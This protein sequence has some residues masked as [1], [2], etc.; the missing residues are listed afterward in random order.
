MRNDADS[1]TTRP[2][3]ATAQG[4][5]ERLARGRIPHRPGSWL[6]V[7]LRPLVWARD[8]LRALYE[9]LVELIWR[10]LIH[11]ET[12][13]NPATQLKAGAL[14]VGFALVAYHFEGPAEFT[15][16]AVIAL[17]ALDFAMA[18]LR[19][20]RPS[21][22]EHYVLERA[23]DTLVW[24]GRAPRHRPVT[25]ELP[26]RRVRCV[27]VDSLSLA[28][29]AFRDAYRHVW[30][31]SLVLDDDRGLPLAESSHPG[32]VL[33]QGHALAAGLGV[34]LEI[35]GATGV[36]ESI[37]A[38]GRIVP[39]VG[40]SPTVHEIDTPD[41]P[42]IVR[43]LGFGE[44]RELVGEVLEDAGLLLFFLIMAGMLPKIGLFV[45]FVTGY[46]PPVLHLDLSPAGLLGFFTPEADDWVGWTELT[47]AI[48]VL[49][50]STWRH[51]RAR[52]LTVGATVTRYAVG[53]REVATLATRRINA[54]FLVHNPAPLVVVAD[55]RGEAAVI[56]GLH[57]AGEAR[58]MLDA[59]ATTLPRGQA[60]ETGTGSSSRPRRGTCPTS[61][62][63]ASGIVD[64]G[65][66]QARA[67]AAVERK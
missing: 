36:G 28:G 52:R 40:R 43:R 25:R 24:K 5:R 49:S 41:G 33:E 12:D 48:A 13:R 6:A 66:G 51:A 3:G 4:G 57:D 21:A 63:I 15:V 55:S 9:G 64:P 14:L 30:R 61:P 47:I 23:G 59:I 7:A 62:D 54:V 50:F 27:G 53:A 11:G 46:G 16:L 56:A 22:Y 17:W 44:L 39:G 26:A 37:P 38:A 32:E 10:E 19:F 67:D 60:K 18:H 34:P 42:Q 65:A 35:M 2:P 8:V 20:R 31:L 58:C 29:G 1:A 45:S